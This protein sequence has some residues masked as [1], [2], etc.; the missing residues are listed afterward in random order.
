MVGG[1]RCQH[2]VLSSSGK[3]SMTDQPHW[4]DL[5]GRFGNQRP[6]NSGAGIS[7]SLPVLFPGGTPQLMTMDRHRGIHTLSNTTTTAYRSLPR[8]Q[9]EGSDLQVECRRSSSLM[10]SQFSSTKTIGP[11]LGQTSWCLWRSFTLILAG[12]VVSTGLTLCCCP[13]HLELSR[14]ATSVPSP[15]PIAFI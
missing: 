4:S 11:G 10:G 8:G 9:S 15:Y 1:K 5:T 3:W 6:S 7:L 12:W 2:K 13:R 14:W